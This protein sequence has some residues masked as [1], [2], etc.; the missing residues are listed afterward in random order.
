M[1][2]TL[3]I[4]VER[5]RPLY[6]GKDPAHR[7]DHI[8]RI[9][10]FCLRVGPP[11]GAD[12]GLL[13]PA[14]LVHGV[15]GDER[16]REVLG[17]RYEEVVNLGPQRLEEPPDPGGEGPPR[18]EPLRR[19]RRHRHSPGL[20]QG[21]LRGTDDRGDPEDHEGE[22]E[23]PAPHPGGETHGGGA[24]RVHEAIPREA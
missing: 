21:R 24:P 16:L 4:L 13:L 19:P 3:S 8:E 17:E 10:D 2:E 1:S 20:H 6:E 14:A 9:I 12:M 15:K 23:T 11:L 18:R 5:V 22:Y 7:F